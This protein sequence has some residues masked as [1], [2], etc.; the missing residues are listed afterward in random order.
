MGNNFKAA[1]RIV[2][3]WSTMT[4]ANHLGKAFMSK[5]EHLGLIVEKLFVNETYGNNPLASEMLNGLKTMKIETWPNYTYDVGTSNSRPVVIMEDVMPSGH[6]HG[7]GGLEFTIKV[8]EPYLEPADEISPGV[9]TEVQARVQAKLGRHG[10]G[11]L[12]LC[13]A[14]ILGD[15]RQYIPAKYFKPGVA[16]AKL[17]ASGEE[18][19]QQKGSTRFYNPGM[20]I[21]MTGGK[22]N[23]LY[24]MT[25]YATMNRLS[26]VC[27]I[28]IQ[29]EGK[30]FMGWVSMAEYQAKTEWM[31]E[32]SRYI[33]FSKTTSDSYRIHGSTNYKVDHAPGVFEQIMSNGHVYPYSLLT[34]NG[35]KEF[36]N[37]IQYGR[38]AP[39]QRG[40]LFLFSGEIGIQKMS[41]VFMN[42]LNRQNIQLLADHFVTKNGDTGI[43][44]NALTIGAQ[45]TRWRMPNGTIIRLVH[46]PAFDDIN[47][48]FELNP[49]TGFP[50][51]S[52]TFVF[53]EIGRDAMNSNT[54]LL[55]PKSQNGQSVAYRMGNVNLPGFANGEFVATHE[56]AFSVSFT[57]YLSVLIKDPTRCGIMYL[58][59]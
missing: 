13:A 11:W 31:Q 5:P 30:K 20:T 34:A 22:I 38:V 50:K 46:E 16:W 25:D 27:Q 10:D 28:G 33:W 15:G 52:E 45:A 39:A 35:V 43:N 19:N 32:I 37:R 40:E 59:Q 48:H 3:S 21:S 57:K 9:P 29:Y 1:M 18:G 54:L 36:I 6:K 44:S 42:E 41:E 24:K 7:F 17:W 47:I 58:N 14:K 56:D 2:P 23:K 12:Y 49:L 55:E 4:D 53:M 8:D 51:F 26:K